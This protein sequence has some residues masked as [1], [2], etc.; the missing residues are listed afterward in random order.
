MGLR[1]GLMPLEFRPIL[2]RIMVSGVPDFSRFNIVDII[3]ESVEAGY[4]LIE[5]SMDLEYILPNSLDDDKIEK[6]VELKDELGH[7]YTVH[8]PLWS[9]EPASFNDKIRSASVNTIISA[10]KQAEKLEPEAYVYHATG[11]LAAEFSRLD[12]PVN[13]RNIIS[14]YMLSYASTSIEEIL[15]GSEIDPRLLAVENVEFPFS[16][17]REMIDEYNVGICFDTGHLLTKYSGEESVIEFYKKHHDRIIEIHLHDGSYEECNG[18][19]LHKDHV[20]LGVGDMPIKEFISLLHKDKFSK[21][22]IFEISKS[23]A[24][25]SLTRI[26]RAVPEAHK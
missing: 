6:L 18:V 2:D 1:F 8:L 20:A 15:A 21:P 9:V 23:E 7:S 24:D 13:I 11:S 4:E 10:I 16:L 17:T 22:I 3:R 26:Q 25:L 12:V 19:P 14:S 5:V